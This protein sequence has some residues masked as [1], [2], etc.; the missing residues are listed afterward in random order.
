MQFINKL[1]KEN[2][3]EGNAIVE[4]F[5]AGQWQDDSQRYVNL[6]YDGFSG[7]RS[8]MVKLTVKEQD[9]FCCYCM[10]LITDDNATLEH[11]I[12]NKTS[13]LAE[14]D[15][16]SYVDILKE[17]V[18]FWTRSYNDIKQFTPPFPHM[19]AYYNLVASC[20]GGIYDYD[21]KNIERKITLNQC[22]NSPRGKKE[23]K[24]LFYFADIEERI[25]YTKDG[26]I[27]V[28][29]DMEDTI[30]I[31]NLNHKSLKRIREAWHFISKKFT[32]NDV[33]VAIDNPDLRDDILSEMPYSI[34]VD[35]TLY[36]DIYWNLLYQY[37]WFYKYYHDNFQ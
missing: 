10:R 34:A 19:I 13:S 37:N 20:N 9:N 17:K 18:V 32:V 33:K 21:Q 7:R 30:E 28:D 3:D 12:P 11:V 35:P 16:Y 36:T 8:E 5:M 29:E 14:F 24:L 25:S 2:E 26:D 31:L 27:S 1:I 23:I 4:T 15:K 22:C 6:D